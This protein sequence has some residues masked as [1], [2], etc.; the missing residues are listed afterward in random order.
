MD[1]L[2][3]QERSEAIIK[4]LVY[5]LIAVIVITVPL[6]FIFSLPEKETKWNEQQFED[7]FKQLNDNEAFTQEFMAKTDS[8]ISLFT[9]YQNET[10]EMVRDKIQLR[11]SDI[12]NQMEDILQRIGKDSIQI[13]LYDNVIFTFNHL[14]MAQRELY[15]AQDELADCMNKT[16]NQKQQLAETSEQVQIEQSKS[17]QEK[18]IDLIKKA[19]EKHNGSVRQAA[20]ELGSTERKLRKRMKELGIDG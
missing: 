12:T 4:V 18:E 2:N 14:F 3:R 16:Q 19:L 10:D 1:P 20:K 15:Q 11:Y 9:A 13:G 7:M 5:Y 17:I 8:A 6:Y